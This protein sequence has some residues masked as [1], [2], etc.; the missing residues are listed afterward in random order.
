MSEFTTVA[1]VG[2]ILEGQGIAYAVNGRMVAVFKEGERY[3]AIDDFCPHMGASLAGGH[4]CD[5]IVVCPWHA[6]RF[7]IKSGQ[8]ADNPRIKIDAF[9]VRV[10]DDEIQVKVLSKESQNPS[11]P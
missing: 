1:K 5:G 8:W 11:S 6:W 7:C 10:V 9:E 3:Y 2:D 4:V